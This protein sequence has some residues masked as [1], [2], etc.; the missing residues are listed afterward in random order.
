M[1]DCG[2]RWASPNK[3]TVPNAGGAQRRHHSIPDLHGTLTT[4]IGFATPL[5]AQIM[6][7]YPTA[8]LIPITNAAGQTS[9]ANA[10]SDGTQVGQ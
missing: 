1:K 4:F 10:F 6:A 7:L 8:G 2:S 9:L 5:I 3:V